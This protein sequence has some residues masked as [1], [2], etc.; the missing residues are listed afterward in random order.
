MHNVNELHLTFLQVQYSE[1][2]AAVCAEADKE[3]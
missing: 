1:P 2:A 3:T